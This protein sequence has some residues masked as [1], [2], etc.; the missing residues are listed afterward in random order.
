MGAS[1]YS[2]VSELIHYDGCQLRNMFLGAD[3]MEPSEG[4]LST[5]AS[6]IIKSHLEKGAKEERQV[7]NE[8]LLLVGSLAVCL[9]QISN[10]W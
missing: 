4:P 5:V 3:Q 10:K 7:L 2:A 6:A 1:N 8:V 9:L